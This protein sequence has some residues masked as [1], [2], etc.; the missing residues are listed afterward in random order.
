MTSQR[1]PITGGMNSVRGKIS[2]ESAQGPKR[3]LAV[4]LIFRGISQAQE[5]I[6]CDS[7]FD[8]PREAKPQVGQAPGAC[9]VKSTLG[10]GKVS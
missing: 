6:R 2:R 4:P 9:V 10:I 7:V 3:R 8:Q 1:L 5:E